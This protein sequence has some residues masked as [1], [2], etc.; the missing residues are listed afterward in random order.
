MATP[1]PAPCP[2]CHVP[3][4]EFSDAKICACEICGEVN[5][6]L[7]PAKRTEEIDWWV[8]LGLP[9]LATF[10]N[11]FVLALVDIWLPVWRNPSIGLAALLAPGALLLVFLLSKALLADQRARAADREHTRLRTAGE[12]RHK[13]WAADRTAA[14]RALWATR[15]DTASR[16]AL[17]DHVRGADEWLSAL[18]E[19]LDTN[20]VARKALD[21][22]SSPAQLESLLTRP[23]PAERVEAVKARQTALAE[24][25]RR[26]TM[27][28]QARLEAKRLAKERAA[29]EAKAR[30]R[31]QAAKRAVDEAIAQSHKKAPDEP[32]KTSATTP[33]IVLF[34][35]DGTR[36]AQAEAV[37]AIMMFAMA[38][39]N[40]HLL[41]GG[42]PQYMATLPSEPESEE[43]IV[44]EY[45]RIAKR[46][47]W[48]PIRPTCKMVSGG[49]K[50]LAIAY[51]EAAQLG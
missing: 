10:A 25:T 41:M 35:L 45:Q 11:L 12:A 4:L 50:R 5:Q 23:L 47:G 40:T 28:E 37:A 13:R 3:S 18:V 51:P 9:A 7:L 22:I 36:P 32:S 42:I 1:A 44:D 21:H 48:N 39:G 14:V 20:A 16:L 6:R 26:R 27:E 34:G 31:E 46:A 24:E 49:G 33:G 29:E 19:E 38:S 17:L 8:T 15:Q 30:D 43:P 2:K